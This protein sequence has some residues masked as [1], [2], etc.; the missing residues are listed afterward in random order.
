MS[1]NESSQDIVKENS[2]PK[3][4]A[5]QFL[6]IWRQYLTMLRK[7]FIVTYRHPILLALEILVPAFLFLSICDDR[8][9]VKGLVAS[10]PMTNLTQFNIDQKIL[11]YYFPDNATIFEKME[12]TKLME[13]MALMYTPA[14]D[15]TQLLALG[16]VDDAQKAVLACQDCFW[17]V[18][19]AKINSITQVSIDYNF[20]VHEQFIIDQE[21]G[22]N[23][24]RLW[25]AQVAQNMI[26]FAIMNYLAKESSI[27]QIKPISQYSN[28]FGFQ[29]LPD[30]EYFNPSGIYNKVAS[31][32]PVVLGISCL[33]S[34][35]AFSFSIVSEKQMKLRQSLHTVGLR[36]S[37][38]WL[39]QFTIAIGLSFCQSFLLNIIGRISGYVYFK[40]TDFGINFVIIWF[41]FLASHTFA[42]LIASIVTH[43]KV[44]SF[45]IFIAFVG[46]FVIGTLCT[47]HLKIYPPF[48][49]FSGWQVF[50]LS[51][52][53][54]AMFLVS[55]KSLPFIDKYLPTTPPG[56]T[57]YDSVHYTGACEGNPCNP[58]SYDSG[59]TVAFSIGM[60]II[61]IIVQT[62]L[63]AYI[64][65]IT[66]SAHGS[67]LP[68]YG[69]FSPEFWGVSKTPPPPASHYP[70]YKRKADL[71]QWD[72]DVRT[73][74]RKILSPLGSADFN[75][76]KDSAIIIY[77]L[78]VIFKGFKDTKHAVNQLSF[79]MPKNQVVGLLGANGAGKSTTLSVLT[80]S[81]K[82]TSGEV[83]IL[84]YS[85]TS[86][87]R[88]ISELLGYA[89]QFDVLW[90]DL[91]P[92]EHISIFA[93]LRG[94]TYEEEIKSIKLART[95]AF[96]AGLAQMED[97]EESNA[98][99]GNGLLKKLSKK[100]A[101]AKLT[102]LRLQDVGLY[103]AQDVKSV[104][105][106]GGMRRRL[107]LCLALVGNPPILMLDEISTGLDPIS[108][109]KIWDVILRAKTDRS[110]LLTTHSMEECDTL[111]DRIA[112]MAHGILR[113][114]G[115]SAHL[116]TRY[117]MGYRIDIS[118]EF[119]PI[120]GVSDV[121]RVRDELVK[122]YM[123]EAILVGRTG[124]HLTLAVARTVEFQ[125]LQEFLKQVETS[126]LVKGWG[127]R[128][129]T[130]EEV[131][132]A[133]NRHADKL[134]MIKGVMK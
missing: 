97:E 66:P 115:S 20:R 46:F 13:E 70:T 111:S 134:E 52:V 17:A 130:L 60:L 129:T 7:D 84:G 128:Q 31:G 55:L 120:S 24:D 65:L 95:A 103:D 14:L 50:F 63:A 101:L 113:C 99:E 76:I 86:Q 23:K 119:D 114:I 124:G 28:Q 26:E 68:I 5:N 22:R 38:F 67:R 21:V 11:G 58:D 1:D 15:N 122:K 79:A 96:R 42:F 123:P 112:V 53:S 92:A 25:D 100:E 105:L 33:F 83:Q 91:S 40:Y 41:F 29:K 64:D 45:V 78:N 62:I 27:E 39:S 127:I 133:I 3:K 37:A 116:K 4:K 30:V 61:C 107:T 126:D 81:L 108:R 9:R 102:Q 88:Q 125:R 69:P 44:L 90:P 98:S 73:E 49:Q 2:Q 72:K 117:G 89:P 47:N 110:V 71:T 121:L 94:L 82:A 59:R 118:C 132:L 87:R 43:I 106:S 56:F 109:R 8:F 93:N 77:D 16:N 35:F 74:S 85:T 131:F 75:S 51:H 36:D 32:A 48:A 19:S 57:W 54:Q 18:F 6:I 34:F 12:L 80:G 104:S 10:Y